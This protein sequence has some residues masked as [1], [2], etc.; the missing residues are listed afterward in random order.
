MVSLNLASDVRIR[1]SRS[2]TNVLFCVSV[3]LWQAHGSVRKVDSRRGRAILVD[4]FQMRDNR[5]SIFLEERG[6]RDF[7]A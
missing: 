4:R 3:L 1:A 2:P 5:L 7:I 6:E